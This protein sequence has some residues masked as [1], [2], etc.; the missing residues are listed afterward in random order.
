MTVFISGWFMHKITKL[1]IT[2]TFLFIIS[3]QFASAAPLGLPE[4]TAKIGYGIG[5]A[6]TSIDDPDGDTA[7]TVGYQPL[8]LVYSDWFMGDFR[9]WTEA[10]YYVAS[11]D[12]SQTEIG[13]DVER[14]GIRFSLQKSFR[15]AGAWA[16]WFGAG[17]DVSQV[18]Y[19]LRHTVDENGYRDQRYPDLDEIAVALLLNAHSEWNV[20][21]NWS[22]GAKLE[23]SIPLSGEILETVLAASILYRY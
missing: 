14:Y 12:A 10:F 8:M 22:I 17:L 6:Y 13:Q 19:T 3:A 7:A 11:L 15:V 23:Q 5:A 16:P 20:S 2:I 18:K 1:S 21:R 4:S 9:Y